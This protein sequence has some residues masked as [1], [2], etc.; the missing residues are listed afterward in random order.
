[1]KRLQI[2]L[3]QEPSGTILLKLKLINIEIFLEHSKNVKVLL[4]DIFNIGWMASL[5]CFVLAYKLKKETL[6]SFD[7]SVHVSVMHINT[8]SLWYLDRIN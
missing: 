4:R 6:T 8:S 7:S 2:T 5:G 1:M 3:N